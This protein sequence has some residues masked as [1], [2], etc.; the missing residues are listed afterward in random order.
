MEQAVAAN[1]YDVKKLPLGKLTVAQIRAGYEAL[2]R[3]EAAIKVP[4]LFFLFF[5]VPKVCVS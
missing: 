3:I 4:L 1:G 5:C 2:S